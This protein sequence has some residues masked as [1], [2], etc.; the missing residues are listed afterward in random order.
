M[1]RKSSLKIYREFKL[2]IKEKNSND[3]RDSSKYLFQA[4]TNTLPL[5][6]TKHHTG[7]DTKCE[8]CDNENEDLIHF[9]IDCKE[10]ENKRNKQIMEKNLNQD[11]E[12]MAGK[13]L[14]GKEDKEDIKYMIDRMWKFRLGKKIQ[15]ENKKEALNIKA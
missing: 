1:E 11:K 10:L 5:N 9:L 14:F 7:G 4:R 3:N 2:K 6:T 13:I 8:L 12:V 15:N